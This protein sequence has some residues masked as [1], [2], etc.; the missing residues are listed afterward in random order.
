MN[1][2]YLINVIL[3]LIDHIDNLHDEISEIRT[4]VKGDIKEISNKLENL[5][6]Y[7]YPNTN[8]NSRHIKNNELWD[9][10]FTLEER[11]QSL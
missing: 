2:K 7:V 6:Q 3:K 8:E 10:K 4:E 9:L 1:E 11:L 5:S